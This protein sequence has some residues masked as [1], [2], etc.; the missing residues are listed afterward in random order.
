M[1]DDTVLDTSAKS[2]WLALNTP[3]EPWQ[4]RLKLVRETSTGNI[5]YRHDNLSFSIAVYLVLPPFR[6]DSV[7]SRCDYNIF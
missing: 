4:L 6:L 5:L 1:Q 3:A 2:L 7:N